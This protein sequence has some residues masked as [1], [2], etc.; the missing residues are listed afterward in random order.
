MSYVNEVVV[1]PTNNVMQPQQ[2]N[3]NGTVNMVLIYLF[4]LAGLIRGLTAAL[5]A[6]E[7]L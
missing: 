5:K 1:A 3:G 7:K 2:F 6:V 4:V